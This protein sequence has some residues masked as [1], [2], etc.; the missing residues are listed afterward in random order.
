MKIDKLIQPVTTVSV[1]DGKR[2]TDI[3]PSTGT[4]QENAS[5]HLSSNAAKLQ[6]I[7]SSSAGGSV[8]DT[9]RV[10]EIKQAISEGN[11]R[12][13]PEVVA[14]RLLETVKELIQSKK[15]DN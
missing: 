1:N 14:D 15:G 9:A 8:V 6:N 2:R 13:N 12:I 11:F 3:T 4:D 5:V 7:D 10:H